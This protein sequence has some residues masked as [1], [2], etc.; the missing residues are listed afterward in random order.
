MRPE[1]YFLS[2]KPQN[3]PCTPEPW[4]GISYCT[5]LCHTKP[6]SIDSLTMCLRHMLRRPCGTLGANGYPPCGGLQHG[7][8]GHRQETSAPP[9]EENIFGAGNISSAWKNILPRG[10]VFSFDP[11]RNPEPIFETPNLSLHP[12]NYLRHPKPTGTMISQAGAMLFEA[13][14]IIVEPGQQC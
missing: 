9:V 12:Q 10:N 4:W 11:A 13:G 6:S 2:L 8:Q 7:L 3:D 14:T 1:P 5:I